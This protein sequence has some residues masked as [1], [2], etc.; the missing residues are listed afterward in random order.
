VSGSATATWATERIVVKK[1]NLKERGG[2][3]QSG[4]RRGSWRANEE[5]DHI[6]VIT[7]VEAGIWEEMTT[8]ENMGKGKS[9]ERWG[10]EEL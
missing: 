9:E 7:A 8:P 4:R 2:E 3:K 10:N 6:S 1:H 5:H